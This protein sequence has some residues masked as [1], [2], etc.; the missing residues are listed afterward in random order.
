MEMTD[1]IIRYTH[2]PSYRWLLKIRTQHFF[3]M[4]CILRHFL[5]AF[6]IHAPIFMFCVLIASLLIAGNPLSELLRGK[7]LPLQGIFLFLL[8]LPIG[9]VLWIF[10]AVTDFVIR[11]MIEVSCVHGTGRD[12]IEIAPGRFISSAKESDGVISKVTL[13]EWK[14]IIAMKETSDSFFIISNQD[15]NSWVI[16]SVMKKFISDAEK[17]K[18]KSI[19]FPEKI[20]LDIFLAKD[21][22][23]KI[24]KMILFYLFLTYAVIACWALS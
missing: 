21:L 11:R 1:D 5:G 23:L 9:L 20:S 8:Y 6:L 15:K 19:D 14:N 10:N 13:A 24:Q 4:R 17:R 2:E 7:S 18:I 12:T 22:H 16:F 3:W